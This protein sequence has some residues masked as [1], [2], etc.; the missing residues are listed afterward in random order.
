M[1]AFE[2][3][4]RVQIIAGPLKEAAVILDAADL[5]D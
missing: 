2:P 4:D 1:K 5:D 3:G